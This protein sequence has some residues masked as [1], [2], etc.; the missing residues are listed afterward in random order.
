MGRKLIIYILQPSREQQIIISYE[1]LLREFFYI[2]IIFCCKIFKLGN[3][4]T[5]TRAFSY[6]LTII[7]L[8]DGSK[9][10]NFIA[11]QKLFFYSKCT[12]FNFAYIYIYATE[13]NKVENSLLIVHCLSH[14]SKFFF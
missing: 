13:L 1:S 4:I 12:K 8:P 10:Q 3:S 2:I 11:W 7:L 9:I 6:P 5:H 14:I